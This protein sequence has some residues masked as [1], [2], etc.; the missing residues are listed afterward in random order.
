M[1]HSSNIHHKRAERK[2]MF[3]QNTTIHYIEA[4]IKDQILY[5]LPASGVILT[6]I[7]HKKTMSDHH[8]S[9]HIQ[10]QKSRISNSSVTKYGNLPYQ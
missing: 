8:S 5:V 7:P 3:P 1:Q 2:F 6:V 9:T 4:S 10:E